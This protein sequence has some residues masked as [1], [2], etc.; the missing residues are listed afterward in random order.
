MSSAT[1]QAMVKPPVKVF[2]IEGRYATALFSAGSKQN[3][4]EAIE[5]DLIKFQSAL[6]KDEVLK[7]FIDN[8]INKR[9]LKASTLLL[10]S[11]KLALSP[12][13]S[14]FLGLLAENGRLQKLNSVINSYK[15]IMAA[16]RGDLSCVVTTAK[17]LDSADQQELK[18][19]LQA[20]AKKG[21]T[22]KIEL[23][24]DPTIIGGMVV[25]I[26]DK[27]VDMSVATKIKKYT[28]IIQDAV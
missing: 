10:A 2:G 16:H 1:S 14:N 11:K 9:S 6:K 4:L 26:G 15:I 13:A 22:I 27:Y 23:K 28:E 17:P 18:K 5:K 19:T 20:F 24:V 7:E 25:S 12:P 3:Q 21:E 8:P